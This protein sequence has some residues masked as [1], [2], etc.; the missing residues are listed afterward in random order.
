MRLG[1]L[2]EVDCVG[3]GKR[4]SVY[5]QINSFISSITEFIE[6]RQVR[7]VVSAAFGSAKE[8][9]NSLAVGS[10]GKQLAEL[11]VCAFVCRSSSCVLCIGLN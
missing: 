3:Y 7:C 8:S 10:V 9:I 11:I 4:L 1:I 6:H 2:E 5:Y